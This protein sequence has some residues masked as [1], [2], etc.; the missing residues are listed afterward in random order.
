MILS[1]LVTK[2]L[3]IFFS[4]PWAVTSIYQFSVFACPECDC[5][6]HFKQDFVNHAVIQ[7]PASIEALWSITDGS[8]SDVTLPADMSH[9][10][11]RDN[12]MSH[13][14][15]HKSEIKL[16]LPNDD[17]ITKVE[18]EPSQVQCYY[19]SDMFQLSQIKGM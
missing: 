1:E 7:H 16:E 6:C 17:G 12:S 14:T 3:P 8:L 10:T 15:D 19:C 13:V 9:V 2:N 5:Y 4:N 11:V 18:F